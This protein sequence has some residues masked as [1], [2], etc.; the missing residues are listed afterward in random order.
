MTS[1]PPG[2]GFNL[3]TRRF[4]RRVDRGQTDLPRDLPAPVTPLA[5]LLT[6]S[7]L[8]AGTSLA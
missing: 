6:H 4:G 7:G 8:A 5:T 3:T 2:W 1:T